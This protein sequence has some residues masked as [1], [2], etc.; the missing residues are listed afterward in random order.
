MQ[1]T[2]PITAERIEMTPSEL[3]LHVQ[4]AVL[5]LP[6]DRCSPCLAKASTP[7]RMDAKLSPGGYGIHW[8]GLDE[9]LSVQ[10]LVRLA[11]VG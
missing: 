2:H 10:G 6:W 11:K 9:D 5:R 4:G 3:V 7:Q 1:S 8:P